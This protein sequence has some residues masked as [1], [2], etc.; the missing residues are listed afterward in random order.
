ME[1]LDISLSKE[2]MDYL[3]SLQPFDKGYPLNVLVSFE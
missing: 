1:A 3:D 2:Q